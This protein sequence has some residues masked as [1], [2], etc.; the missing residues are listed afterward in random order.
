MLKIPIFH[1]KKDLSGSIECS[2]IKLPLYQGY[3]V[4]A[5]LSFIPFLLFCRNKTLIHF[6]LFMFLFKG[7]IITQKKVFSTSN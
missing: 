7:N 2:G 4:I 6:S 1:C 3:S 5:N